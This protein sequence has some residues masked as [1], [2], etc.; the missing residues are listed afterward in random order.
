MDSTGT[1]QGSS[2]A[3]ALEQLT[4]DLPPDEADALLITALLLQDI[5]ALESSRKGKA[6]DGS[7]RTDEELAFG[8]LQSEARDIVSVLQDGLMARSMDNAVATDR[9]LIRELH[10]LELQAAQDRA[11]AQAL[12]RGELPAPGQVK[13]EIFGE[14]G[15]RAPDDISQG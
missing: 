8:L 10:L 11:Y 3:A 1:S 5:A 4:V 2:S 9:D 6:R 12:E 13:D 15:G 7:P 14:A